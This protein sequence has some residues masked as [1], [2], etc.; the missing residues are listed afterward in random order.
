MYW[1]RIFTVAITLILVMGAGC[2]TSGNKTAE[3]STE[4]ESAQTSTPQPMVIAQ[5]VSCGK[6][7]MYPAKYPRWQSQI[8]FKDGSMT[9]FDGCKCT[10]FD[11]CKCMFN[12][13][14]SMDKYDKAHSMDDVAAVW[15]KDFSNGTWID[16]TEAHFVV[17][18]KMMGPMGK[19]LIPFADH[20]AAMKFH[21][22]QG[23]NMMGYAEITPEVLKSLM[24][25][26]KK[27][28]H[29][30]EHGHMKM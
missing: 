14:L 26:M 16:G 18:S 7:G 6:C 28:G 24:G 2:A 20:A 5:D 29:G 22:E 25:G 17:G 3:Q 1:K 19:E 10:P 21:H 13:M 4:T 11:G 15:V 23:G 8:I 27:H 30:S 12:L 9:P